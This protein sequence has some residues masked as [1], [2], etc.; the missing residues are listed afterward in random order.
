[1]T[2]PTLYIMASPFRRIDPDTR[3]VIT[4]DQNNNVVK[5]EDSDGNLLD[6]PLNLGGNTALR[7]SDDTGNELS[8]QILAELKTMNF[9]L[10]IITGE[11]IL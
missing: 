1:M 4:I 8:R 11:E 10:Q 3:A 2:L 7:V 5:I 6:L 9:H